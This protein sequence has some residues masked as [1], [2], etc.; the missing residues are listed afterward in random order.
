VPDATGRRRKLVVAAIVVAAGML[1]LVLV[2][3]TAGGDSAAQ[4]AVQQLR[5]GQSHD[6]VL[7][8][9]QGVDYADAVSKGSGLVVFNVDGDDVWL[10]MSSDHV[11][12]IQRFAET[13]PAWERMGRAFERRLLALIHRF[14]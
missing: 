9:L 4:R 11:V 8:I 14:R 2:W 12:K 1:F 13:G 3:F 10:A 6:E 5:L 7:Q